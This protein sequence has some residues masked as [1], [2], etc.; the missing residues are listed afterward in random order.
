MFKQQKLILIF[1][2]FPAISGCASKKI[3]YTTAGAL[4]GAGGGYAIDHDG[5]DAAIGGLAGGITGAIVATVHEKRENKKFN[6][7]FDQGYTQAQ[8]EIAIDDWK[9]NTGRKTDEVYSNS[10]HRIRVPTKEV[11]NVIYETHFE[12]LEVYQ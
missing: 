11:N 4:I 2:L 12:T 7:G 9:T 5:K 10:Y 1:I 8:L 3:P 6:E